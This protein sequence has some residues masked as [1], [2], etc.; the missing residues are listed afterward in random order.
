MILIT[1]SDVVIDMKK[2][3]LFSEPERFLFKKN[4]LQKRVQILQ[5]NLSVWVLFLFLSSLNHGTIRCRIWKID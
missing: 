2:V 4:V 5:R 3:L 1:Y